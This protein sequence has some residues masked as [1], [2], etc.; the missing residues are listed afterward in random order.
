MPWESLQ[1][2]RVLSKLSATAQ[3]PL[4]GVIQIVAMTEDA[5]VPGGMRILLVHGDP[6]PELAR[7]LAR[8]GHHVLAVAE[9]DRPAAFWVCST[10]S[11][12][13]SS[14]PTPRRSAMTFVARR[15][16]SR[17][18]QSSRA[19]MSTWW[20]LRS[21]LGPTTAW[22]GHFTEPSWLP[23]SLLH[24][25][26]G[27]SRPRHRRWLTFRRWT[28]RREPPPA[29]PVAPVRAGIGC[30]GGHGAGDHADR[31]A[32]QLRA[33]LKAGRDRGERC[34]PV[35]RVGERQY[36]GRDRPQRQLPDQRDPVARV[37]LRRSAHH[38]GR[39]DRDA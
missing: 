25:G 19:A 5:V 23:G 4:S 32:E 15:A 12:C 34:H 17:S 37:R 20:S 24:G 16:M 18:S 39:A 36:R 33:N 10:P 14:E 22:A 9:G 1:P 13:S 35:D 6:E 26:A 29:A 11:S 3:P 31:S 38:R 21:R 8:G 30:G 28:V 7:T 27:R 2:A